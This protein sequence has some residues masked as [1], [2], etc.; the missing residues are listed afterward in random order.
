MKPVLNDV[1]CDLCTTPGPSGF[2]QD[3]A[4]KVK[5]Y[6]APVADEITVDNVGNV[7]ARIDGTDPSLKPA[8]V[9]AHMDRVGMIVSFVHKDGHLR[10]QAIGGVPDKVLPGS[11]VQVR[12]QDG[13]WQT[14]VVG[15]KCNHLMT[16]EE[17]M[18]TQP[19]RE[20]LVDVGAT[21]AEDARQ[22]G[23]A[24]GCPVVYEPTFVPLAGRRVAATALDNCGCVAALI[25]IARQLFQ[26]RPP[27]T[28]YLAATVWEEYNQ[29]AA[30]MAVAK[31]NPV[32][33]ISMDM[34]LAG[35]TPDVK[36]VFEAS[37]G[38]GPV[39]SHFNYSDGVDNGTIAHP[40][41]YQLA[42]R[43]AKEQGTGLQHYVCYASLGDNAFSQLTGDG[44]AC[45]EIGAPVRYAHSTT[46]VADLDDIENLSLLIASMVQSLD[47]SFVQARYTL[48]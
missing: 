6:L 15:T 10:L 17:K 8:M 28:T 14:G 39:A 46:E 2:E 7:I 19:M 5:D 3:I 45:I 41:L 37:V 16:E 13:R 33:S 30:A 36:G 44:P 25:G 4:Q 43:V 38:C 40:G 31:I 11:R 35:D 22:L 18:R 48:D 42:E 27:R 12:T 1:L 23:F 29:R 47:A 32:V 21:S 20:L 26:S 24:I 34:L 9:Y